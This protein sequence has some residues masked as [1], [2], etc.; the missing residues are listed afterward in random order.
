MCEINC[1]QKRKEK[2]DEANAYIC[3]QCIQNWN[4][5]NLN[6]FVSAIEKSVNKEMT[7]ALDNI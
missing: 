3:N 2:K 6:N 7:D 1:W 4:S 5:R